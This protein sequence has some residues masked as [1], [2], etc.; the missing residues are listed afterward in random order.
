MTKP[1]IEVAPQY[2]VNDLEEEI[3]SL[4][5]MIAVFM[6]DPGEEEAWVKF[7]FVS[8]MSQ[9]CDFCPSPDDVKGLEEKLGF[10]VD[11]HDYLVAIATKMRKLKTVQ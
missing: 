6:A 11:R 5:R 8:D 7:C 1:K 9:L 2:S 4:L 10:P 3:D